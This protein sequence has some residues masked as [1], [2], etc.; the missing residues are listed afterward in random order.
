MDPL[1][2][3]RALAEAGRGGDEGQLAACREP[4]VEPFQQAWSGDDARSWGRDIEFGGENG[5]SHSVII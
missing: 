1:A 5:Q 2:D 3:E 4:V